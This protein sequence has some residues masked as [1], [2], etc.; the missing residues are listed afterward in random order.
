MIKHS[1]KTIER[2]LQVKVVRLLKDQ[3]YLTNSGELRVLFVTSQGDT[4][5]TF[6]TEAEN[7]KAFKSSYEIFHD[8]LFVEGSV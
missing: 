3:H 7:K 6:D 4:C 2:N 8:I 5:V 1:G